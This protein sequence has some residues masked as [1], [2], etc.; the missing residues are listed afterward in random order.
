MK[1]IAAAVLGLGV[2]VSTPILADAAHHPEVSPANAQMPGA[3]MMAARMDM[4]QNMVGGRGPM[5]KP[6]Q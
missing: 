2:L 3:D 6:G 4:M 1:T 5:G